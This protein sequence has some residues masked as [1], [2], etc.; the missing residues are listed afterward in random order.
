MVPL[1]P[2]NHVP[3]FREPRQINLNR[4]SKTIVHLRHPRIARTRDRRC[5]HLARNSCGSRR[6]NR[7]RS[8]G[9]SGGNSGS[10]NR[11]SGGRGRNRFG[12]GRSDRGGRCRRSSSGGGGRGRSCNMSRL[13]RGR[14]DGGGFYL[15]VHHH[16]PIYI[17]LG[18]VR[19]ALFRCAG[20]GGLFHR[21]RYRHRF[22][23]GGCGD[24]CGNLHHILYRLGFGGG[25]GGRSGPG[26]FDRQ[27]RLLFSAG[28]G[29]DGQCQDEGY[30]WAGG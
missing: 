11:C 22:G 17:L 20:F 18:S 7:S 30:G 29:G 24:G 26:G 12:R 4:T 25:A 28:D 15:C 6:R 1:L 5:Y 3:H 27:R 19:R 23:F 16:Y 2:R 14:R 10:R 9:R 21:H 13:R 8:S